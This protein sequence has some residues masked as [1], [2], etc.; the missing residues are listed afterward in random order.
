MSLTLSGDVMPARAP[1][2]SKLVR[3]WQMARWLETTPF[4]WLV[5]PEV[6]RIIASSSGTSVTAG[7]GAPAPADFLYRTYPAA[8]QRAFALAI[9]Q[10]FGYD[11]QRGLG[12]LFAYDVTG[13]R[14]E[15]QDF[16][17][18][19]SGQRRRSCAL[20]SA[21]VT[22][23]DRVPASAAGAMRASWPVSASTC[24]KNFR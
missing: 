9:A 2:K 6:Y 24:S 4:A 13:G 11:L 5:V 7:T 3:A 14:Y 8:Q 12:R 19:G 21:T 15:E 17:A 10:K 23:I 16:V 18:T 1:P 22:P 20:A